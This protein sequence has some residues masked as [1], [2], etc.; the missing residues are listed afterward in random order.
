MQLPH[1]STEL[2]ELVGGS[3]IGDHTLSLVQNWDA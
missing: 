3:I 2:R 1:T